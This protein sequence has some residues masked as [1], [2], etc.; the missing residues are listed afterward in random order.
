MIVKVHHNPQGIVVAVCDSEL[1]GKKFETERLQLDLTAS[2]Y[3]GAEM[4]EE[5]AR[6]VFRKAH[7]LN[8]VG[9]KSIEFCK[10]EGYVEEGHVI[11]IAGVPHA[12][13]TIVRN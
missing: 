1:L 5:E 9:K 6:E 2:F 8:I 3:D 7:I 4:T 12:Q 11:V 13:V 10:K